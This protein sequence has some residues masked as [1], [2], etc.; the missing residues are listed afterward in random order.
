MLFHRAKD[1]AGRVLQTFAFRVV[2]EVGEELSDALFGFL[3]VQ[4]VSHCR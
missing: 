1:A 3:V 2:A 4:L